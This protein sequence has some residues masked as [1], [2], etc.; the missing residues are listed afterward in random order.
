[1]QEK[2]AHSDSLSPKDSTLGAFEVTWL[3]HCTLSLLNI[4]MAAGQPPKHCVWKNTEAMTTRDERVREMMM[5]CLVPNLDFA[6]HL[7]VNAQ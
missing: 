5:R 4:A 2:E 6:D 1:M 3:L 7:E